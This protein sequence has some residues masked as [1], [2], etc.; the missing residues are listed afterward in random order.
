MSFKEKIIISTGWRVKAIKLLKGN[1]IIHCSG[2]Q[3][4]NERRGLYVYK[5]SISCHKT[6]NVLFN[7][8][9]F[10]WYSSDFQNFYMNVFVVTSRIQ[11]CCT[12]CVNVRF[13]DKNICSFN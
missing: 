1:E 4:C 10:S 13:D 2:L 5:A 11:I 7:C 12:K 6:Y 8:L 3:V 9:L